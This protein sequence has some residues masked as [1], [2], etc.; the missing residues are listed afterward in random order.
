VRGPESA[1]SS[2]GRVVEVINVET[3]ERQRVTTNDGGGFTVKVK[4][5]NYRVELALREGESLVRA[6]GVMQVNRNGLDAHADFI[7]GAGRLSRP[8]G[9]AYRTDDGLGSPV[10]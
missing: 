7:I 2:D 3:N 9:P 10:A 1:G 8:R 5:G 4:P 6:P